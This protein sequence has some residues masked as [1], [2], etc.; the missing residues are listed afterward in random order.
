VHLTAQATDAF[1]LVLQQVILTHLLL[2]NISELWKH[3][4]FPDDPYP[5]S[6]FHAIEVLHPLSPPFLKG[7]L[8][9]LLSGYL[10]PPGPPLEKGGKNCGFEFHSNYEAPL[11]FRNWNS[12][13]R[14]QWEELF[15]FP[16]P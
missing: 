9:G 5:W 12:R 11:A 4:S 13:V 6:S 8:G 14:S 1:F 15:F 7:D 2:H 3:S 16:G 10:I